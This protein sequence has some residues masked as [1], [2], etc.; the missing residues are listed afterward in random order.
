[1]RQE[2][3]NDADDWNDPMGMNNAL[4]GGWREDV[5]SGLADAFE[6]DE[7]NYWNID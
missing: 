2:K 5:E 3:M 4:H 7:S 1:M 6:G